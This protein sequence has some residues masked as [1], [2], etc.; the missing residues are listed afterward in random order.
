MYI[1]PYYHNQNEEELLAFM[2][3]HPFAL[4]T[5]NGASVPWATHLPFVIEKHESRI[6]L[7]SHFAFANPHGQALEEGDSVLIVFSGPNAYISPSLYDHQ[8]NV[9]T[10]NYIAVHATGVFRSDNSDEIKEKVLQKMIGF[11]EPAY[12]DQWKS[13][14]SEYINGLMKGILA[15]SVELTKL[16]GKFKLSQNKTAAEQKR[17]AES[18]S[19]TELKKHMKP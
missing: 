13:L 4:I 11:F 19:D 7:Y 1:P 18:L 3:A 2:Q 8:Q 14:S 10:W 6:V 16:E 12:Q 17:I 15:F 5:S 9:P